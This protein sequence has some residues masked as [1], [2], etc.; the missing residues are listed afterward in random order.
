MLAWA[1]F[2]TKTIPKLPKLTR[3][4]LSSNFAYHKAGYFIPFSSFL[5][6]LTNGTTITWTY[7]NYFSCDSKDIIYI[8]ICKTCDNFYLGQTQDFKQRTAKHKSDVKNTYNSTCRICSKHLRDCNQAEP[9]FQIVLFYYETDTAL[10][11]YKEKRYIPRWKPP[12]N[13]NKTWI[14]MELINNF[15]IDKFLFV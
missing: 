12:L 11:K 5:F 15:L 13:L 3:L 4:F 10:R 7:E 9:Y 14:M 1:K 2:E 6:K 8:L